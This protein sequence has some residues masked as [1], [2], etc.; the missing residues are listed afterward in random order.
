MRLFASLA[1]GIVTAVSTV[2]LSAIIWT[3][4]LPQQSASDARTEEST[5]GASWILSTLNLF[6]PARS[7]RSLFAVMVENQEDARPFHEGLDEA[8]L[9]QEMIVEGGI[10]RF[11]VLFDAKAPPKSV[12]PVRSLRPYFVSASLPYVHTIIHAGG[13]PEA[14]EK[15]GM[16]RDELTAINLLSSD[17]G[18]ANYRRNDIPA[19]HNV[20]MSEEQIV[21]ILSGAT[22]P[23]AWPLFDEG[24]LTGEFEEATEIEIDFFS[25]LHD[26]YF[27]FEK[28][29][30]RYMRTNGD[31]ISD[32]KPANILIL[33]SPITGVGEFGRLTIP[34]T[35]KGNALLFRNGRAAKVMWE[36]KTDE[37]RFRLT[38]AD[39]KGVKLAKGQT[40]M[41]VLPT[42]DRVEWK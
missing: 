28:T 8:L 16:Y 5:T 19:P 4:T 22:A 39:G 37:E 36:K 2:I 26:V 42:L 38:D 33:E 29:A 1:I 17:G 25:R 35:G 9:I 3:A 34:L 20:F 10:S 11:A 31:D 30:Q 32:A 21:T 13:S 40:W 15:A 41:M 6:P 27:S 24:S 14:F 7:E 12:G 18:R 23:I